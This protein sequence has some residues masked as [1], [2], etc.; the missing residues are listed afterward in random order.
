MQ[1]EATQFL[2]DLQEKYGGPIGFKT[3]STWFASD[4][5]I[6]RPYGVFLFFIGTTVYFED[7]ERQPSIL[8]YPLKAS[9]KDAPYVPYEQH[10]LAQQV[11]SVSTVLKSRAHAY[12]LGELSSQKLT[13]IGTWQRLLR[14]LV[15]RLQLQDG[16]NYFFE[17]IDAKKFISALE[18][19]QH[20]NI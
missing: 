9:K 16:T 7:F 2:L 6:V 11:A 19:S 14:S 10:F 17:L 4:G 8:G 1:A 20:E 15:T 3:Y 5:G 12:A 18:E 13:P